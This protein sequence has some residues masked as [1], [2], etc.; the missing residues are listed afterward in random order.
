MSTPAEARGH[1]QDVSVGPVSHRPPPLRAALHGP[2]GSLAREL[3]AD[4]VHQL[5]HAAAPKNRPLLAC[6][7]CGMC[8]DEVVRLQWQ[9][10]DTCRLLLQVPGQASRVLPLSRLLRVLLEAAGKGVVVTAPSDLLFTEGAGKPLD[11]T[12]VQAIVLIS[13]LDADLSDPETVTPEALRHTYMAFFVRQ[14]VRLSE[15]GALVGGVSTDMLKALTTLA[16]TA[17]PG[18]RVGLAELQPLLPALR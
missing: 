13:A 10:L 11:T 2:V 5:L 17:P 1:T 18:P 3:D 6:L 8:V 4:E 9:H 15:L 7:L 12:G 14:G 16:Q